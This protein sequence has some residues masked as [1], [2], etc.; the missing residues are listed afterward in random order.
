MGTNLHV[1][2]EGLDAVL[3][4]A[5]VLLE[6]INVVLG[7]EWV[8]AIKAARL[9]I[10]SV[11]ELLEA[12]LDALHF[13]VHLLGQPLQSFESFDFFDDGLVALLV[14]LHQ[15]QPHFLECVG[16]QLGLHVHLVGVLLE[17]APQV[18]QTV[19]VVLLH[20]HFFVAE[21]RRLAGQL[22]HLDE[23]QGETALLHQH[24]LFPHPDEQRARHGAVFF[25]ASL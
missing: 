14:R 5:Q 15:S 25:G 6:G 13:A 24:E 7:V 22:L 3:N 20:G 4:Q 16:A 2:K 12:S 18:P 19:L 9:F 11:F 21:A 17:L 8:E 1:R 23:G 10:H